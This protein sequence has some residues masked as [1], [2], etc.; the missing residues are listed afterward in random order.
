LIEYKDNEVLELCE[1][2]LD[3]PVSGPYLQLS[4]GQQL[5]VMSFPWAGYF[6]TLNTVHVQ[7]T[8]VL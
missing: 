6:E 5:P 1:Y 2:D 3:S 7:K 8:V 4:D